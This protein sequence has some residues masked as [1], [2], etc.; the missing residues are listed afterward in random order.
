MYHDRDF[1]L[2]IGGQWSWGSGRQKK[3]ILDPATESVIGYI[4]D[5]NVEDIDGALNAAAAGFQAWRKVQPWD[6]SEKLHKGLVLLRQRID[7]AEVVISTEF[8]QPR[9]DSNGER[10]T[11][12]RKFI[13]RAEKY[14]GLIGTK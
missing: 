10:T 9:V 6:R 5:A 7:E 4:P 11:C 1:G 12:T 13:L 8:E 3:P 14:N 2:Y